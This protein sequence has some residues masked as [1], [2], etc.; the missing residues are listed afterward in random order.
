[1]TYCVGL[2]VREGLVLI[3]DT[4]TNAGLDNIACFRKLHVFEKPDERVMAIASSGNLSITQA[5]ISVLHEGLPD[6]DSGELKTLDDAP[7]MFHAAQ[8]VGRAVREVYRIDG[9]SLEQ[10]ASNFDIALL[11]GGQIKGGRLQLFMM[12]S[13][14]NFIE[15]SSDTPFLQIGEHKYGKPVLDRAIS[16][17]TEIYD[18]LKIGLISMDSTMRS[19][20]GV[21]LPL[22]VL[23]LRRDALKPELNYRIE[24]EDPY[25]SDLR[26]RW[27]E[28]LRAAHLNIPRPPYKTKDPAR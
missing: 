6:P 17:D 22:D 12:Y 23:V 3:S 10:H 18:A 28:A 4:R 21:G 9:P 24:A 5:V 26:H 25:F 16:Y 19:N 7:S 14:G 1:M 27:S 13:A 20:L 8:M 11:L 2:A 15:A